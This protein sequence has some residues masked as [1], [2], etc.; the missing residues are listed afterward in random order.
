MADDLRINGNQVL[1]VIRKEPGVLEVE[2]HWLA[3]TEERPPDHFHPEQD[4]R[5]EI[6]DG[7]LEV[8]LDGET[9]VLRAGDSLDVP[10]NAVHEMRPLTETRARWEVRPALDTLA[11][12]ETMAELTSRGALGRNGVP[13]LPQ[14]A[15]MMGE[16]DREFRLAS[17]PRPVQKLVFGALRP[18]ARA[19]GLKGRYAYAG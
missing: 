12:F 6:I 16:F 9:R 17:P 8:K 14:I 15:L 19:K 5:F 2:S 18:L 7:E 3:G 10:R 1:S 11:M 13:S 4:E